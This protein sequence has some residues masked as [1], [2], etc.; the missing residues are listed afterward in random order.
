MRLT[1]INHLWLE[2]TL[3]H[4]D[5]AVDATLGNGFD[6]LFLAQQLGSQGHLYGFDVQP[7]AITSTEQKLAETRCQHTFYLQGHQTMSTA[8][9]PS[10]KGHIK[11]IMFN[12]GWLPNSDKTIIT[13]AD[14]TISA[15]EQSLAWLAVG[16]K[17]SIMLY[18]GHQGGD[19]EAA[20]VC[21]W[22]EHTCQTS[23]NALTFDKVIVPHRPTA[24]ILLKIQ[25]Q[26]AYL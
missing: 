7:Q 21:N 25:K 18:P 19:S 9:P 23:A 11:V 13:Q 26:I 15:L 16:G 1:E 12:L 10:I 17:L 20:E 4:G 3:Q 8:L 22:L 14:T 2:H 6:A 5:I 24:P